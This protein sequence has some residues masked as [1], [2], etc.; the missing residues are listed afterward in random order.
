MKRSAAI[1][2]ISL[3]AFV[4]GIAVYLIGYN[5][6]TTGQE[7]A[8]MGQASAQQESKVLDVYYPGTEV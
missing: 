8:V 4:V 6:G 5:H 7:P 1:A 3:A 2:T